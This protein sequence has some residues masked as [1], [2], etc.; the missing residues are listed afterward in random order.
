MCLKP[1]R[2]LVELGLYTKF[3]LYVGG[4]LCN[5][6]VTQSMLSKTQ[7]ARNKWL[8]MFH[9]PCTD[10]IHKTFKNTKKYTQGHYL[11][12]LKILYKDC[13]DISKKRSFKILKNLSLRVAYILFP[14]IVI[15]SYPLSTR[16][17]PQRRTVRTFNCSHAAGFGAPYGHKHIQ[18]Y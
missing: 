8:F 9:V 4:H 16:Q 5:Y 7:N 17:C 11:N 12:F 18:G 10:Q 3:N 2:L 6:S 15:D 14:G 1:V 13:S